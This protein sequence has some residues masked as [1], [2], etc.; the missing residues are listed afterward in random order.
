MAVWTHERAGGTD[1]PVQPG[2]VWHVG[3]HVFVC[4]DLMES[5]VFRELVE[6]EPVD[7]VYCDPPWNQSLLTGFRTKAGRPRQ[8]Y[9]VESLYQAIVNL[10]PGAPTYIEG[11]VDDESWMWQIL[12][13]PQR[14][15]FVTT[16][17][18]AARRSLVLYSGSEPCPVDLAG[19]DDNDTPA[20][21]MRH[22]EPGTVVDAC[23]GLG[24]T[25]RSAE[26]TGWRAVTNELSP[27]RMSAAMASVQR[28]VK[29]TVEKY[30]AR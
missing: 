15:R 29:G 7:L 5:S 20:H 19:M 26:L 18:N 9:A 14:Q 13:G 22:Y 1:F 12:P 10:A 8:K 17:A 30:E 16:Y 25:A 4:S 3:R 24:L 11:G 23:G 21:V 6:R 28:I 2:E 27:W